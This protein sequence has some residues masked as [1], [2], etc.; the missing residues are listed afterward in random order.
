MHV[1]VILQ[2][3]CKPQN[4]DKKK[5]WFVLY[6]YAWH[7]LLISSQATVHLYLDL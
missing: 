2:G 7:V 4:T 3:A 6:K 1:Y 5:V